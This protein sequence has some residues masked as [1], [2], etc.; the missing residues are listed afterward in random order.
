[1]KA[2]RGRKLTHVCKA[3]FCLWRFV[4]CYCYYLWTSD[5]DFFSPLRRTFTSH[6]LGSFPSSSCLKPALCL[7]SFLFCGFLLF[8]QS[9]YWVLW[10]SSIADG[11][12]NCPVSDPVGPSI[13]SPYTTVHKLLFLLILLLWWAIMNAL[14]IEHIMSHAAWSEYSPTYFYTQYL[15]QGRW[16]YPHFNKHKAD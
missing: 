2:R 3:P 10:I 1:M 6:S 8:G 15:L 14:F 12:C 9:S 16:Y 13:K 11:H 4:F 5:S 7:W